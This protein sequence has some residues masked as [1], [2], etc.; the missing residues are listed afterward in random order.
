MKTATPF[1][2]TVPRTSAVT[3]LLGVFFIFTTIGFVEDIINMGRAPAPHL[4]LSVLIYGLFCMLYAAAGIA[5]RG[6]AWKIILPL[7]AVQY[8]L[9]GLVEQWLPNLPVLSQ[10]GPADISRLQSRLLF[11]GVATILAV[12]LG[13]A[14]IVYA[15]VAEG[16]R[17]FRVHAE[18]A[19]AAEIHRVL[20]PAIEISIGDFE[21]YG[22]SLPSGE[23][24]GDLID[25][26]QG[27]WGWIA[28]V[29]DVSGHGVAPG[30]IMGMVK[31]AARMHLSCSHEEAE[32]LTNL[33]SV[34]YSI[35][36]P[37]TFVTFA[38]LALNRGRLEYSLAGHP[39]ILH[40]HAASKDITEV[41]CSNLPVAMFDGQPYSSG[42]VAAAPDDLFLL[43][44]DGLL[45]VA[46]A[47]NEDFGLDRVK[48]VVTA[49]AGKPLPV[50]F[51]AI[52]DAARHHGQT[53]DDQ[54][55]L[56]ARC[57]TARMTT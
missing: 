21:F 27:D 48:A 14:G 37:E 39:P 54:S 11:D 50:I 16:R 1:W 35:T 45:E 41:I 20:V 2:R 49:Q 18:M 42:S 51:Q 19:L 10:M 30:V 26:F 15:S 55:L 56:L 17:Y 40:Y 6:Q 3:F 52:V 24:G 4:V 12:S 53:L 47:A 31:S 22:R 38:Y 44:T 8:V 29:A 43:L 9:L 32:L 36:K 7:F 5:L 28:Y 23:V 25:V 57:K 33:N 46:N 34:L 13:Y